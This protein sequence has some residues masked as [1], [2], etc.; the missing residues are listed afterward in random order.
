MSPF[1]DDLKP[2]DEIPKLVKG[3]VTRQHLA[4][5]CAAENDY[6]PI[7]YDERLAKTM[8]LPGAPIQ[9]TYRYA[10]MGQMVTRWLGADGRLVKISCA[11]RGLN[12]EDETITCR[13]T[14]Q[15]LESES[16]GG[17]VQLEI[18]VE[19]AKGERSSTGA[20]TVWLPRRR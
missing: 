12:L 1:F 3:P 11:Y 5:W 20:A 7:H 6:Y 19:N 14:V 2:G 16:D 15:S 4:E 17:R 9:G 10:L 8:G 13:G 18:W